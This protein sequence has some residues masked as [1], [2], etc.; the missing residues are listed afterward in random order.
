MKK[1]FSIII[2]MNEFII[3]NDYNKA[4]IEIKTDKFYKLYK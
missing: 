4:K 2:H 3:L 1:L